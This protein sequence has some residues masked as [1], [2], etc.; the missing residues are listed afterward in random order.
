MKRL[1]ILLGALLLSAS[2]AIADDFVYLKCVTKV[3][4]ARKDLKSNKITKREETET[5]HVMVNLTKSLTLT[6]NNP[7]WK[8][9]KI[10]NGVA[11]IEED[12]SENGFYLSMKATMQI[13]PPG[14]MTGDAI[15]RND[16]F[17]ETFKAR[18][19]CKGIDESEFEKALKEAQS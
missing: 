15:Q 17:S 7:T 13:V 14:P 4:I 2:P 6:A 8:E 11:I 12:R 19:M 18:G 9:D 3:T 16:D 5:E 10:V 1:S